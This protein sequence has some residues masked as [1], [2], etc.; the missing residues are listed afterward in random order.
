MGL[1]CIRR[2]IQFP[3]S[4][5]IRGMGG[6]TST[7]GPDNNYVPDKSCSIKINR[8]LGL[9]SVLAPIALHCRGAKD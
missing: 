3:V 2:G 9:F 8:P 5:S 6:A 7:V 4:Y 1:Y